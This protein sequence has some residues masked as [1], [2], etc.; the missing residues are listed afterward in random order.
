MLLLYRRL[1]GLAAVAS[2]STIYCSILKNLHS[3]HHFVKPALIRV[4]HDFHVAKSKGRHL[5]PGYGT[6]I[7]FYLTSCNT[8]LVMT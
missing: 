5:G 4:I 3:S 6:N 7:I 8:I 2:A 1:S